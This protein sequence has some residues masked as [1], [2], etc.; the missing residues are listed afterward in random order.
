MHETR[1]RNGYVVITQ[2]IQ[3]KLFLWCREGVIN[4]KGA[5]RKCIWKRARAATVV[6]V[7]YS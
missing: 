2:H 5:C 1:C 7:V 3:L 4:L 6:A